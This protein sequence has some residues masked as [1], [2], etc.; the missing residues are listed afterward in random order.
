VANF[1]LTPT[2]EVRAG[3]LRQRAPAAP[4]EEQRAQRI[5]RT[6]ARCHQVLFS[7]YPFTWEGGVRARNPGGSNINSGEARDLL[8][9]GCASRMSCVTCHDPHAPDNRA[10][11]DAL[12]GP[13]GNAICLGCH[14]QFAAPGALAA[15]S[16]HRADGAGALCMNCHMPR[17]NMSLDTRLARYHRIG[18]PTDVARVESD[19][20]LECALCH[21]DRTV[22]QLVE[23]MEAWWGKRYDRAALGALY[24][25]LDA[26]P[27]EVTMAR[28]KAHEQAAAIATAGQLRGRE[29]APLV[30]AQLVHP[31]PIVRYYAARALE[32]MLGQRSPIDLHRSTAQI[33]E[34]A[35]RWLGGFGL[36]MGEPGVVPRP[37]AGDEE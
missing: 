9:G 2:F 16:H 24:G 15:H 13:S 37:P 21:A 8:L 14:G 28:G 35:A 31:Y 4:P 32:T 26:N 20:P 33:R 29:L 17:K 12:E 5:N 10:R 1:N 23:S 19:R 6:C 34:Q 22:R 11:M 3:F 36:A 27:I 30:A 25:S 7:R 18:S